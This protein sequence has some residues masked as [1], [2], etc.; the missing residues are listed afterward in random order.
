M[1]DEWSDAD[2]LRFHRSRMPTPREIPR[3][4]RRLVNQRRVLALLDESLRSVGNDR[5]PVVK[6]LLGQRG[7]GKSTVAV[8]WA[9]KYGEHF[10]DGQLFANLGAWTDHTVAPGEVLRGFLVSLGV[11]AGDVPA[12]LERRASMFRTLTSSRKY[13]IVLDDAVSPAQVRALLPNR[14]GSFVLVTGHGAFA[15]LKQVGAEL[16][17]VAPLEQDGAVELLREFAE[18]RVDAE[19]EALAGILDRCGGLPIALCQVGYVLAEDPGLSLADLLEEV[20]DQAGGMTQMSLGDMPSLASIFGASY[21]RLNDVEQRCYRALGLAPGGGPLPVAAL[22]ATLD[23]PPLQARRVVRELV[24]KKI[25]D[26]PETGSLVVHNLIREHARHLS[27]A[28]DSDDERGVMRMSILRWYETNA[29]AADNKLNPLRGW[30]PRIFPDVPIGPSPADPG[31]WLN[32]ER[33]NLRWAVSTAYELGLRDVVEHLC[34][35]LWSL[36]EPRKYYDD[37]LATHELGLQMTSGN[38]LARA[39]MLVQTSFALRYKGEYEEALTRCRAAAAI[40][41]NAKN[42]ELEATA[43]EAAG[44]TELDRDN[45]GEAVRL[46]RRN[47]ELAE[48]IGDSRRIALARMHLAKAEEPYGA[49]D[50]LGQAYEAFKRLGDDRN[51][52]KVL[53]WQGRR[54]RERG[55]LVEADRRLAQ[56]ADLLAEWP[57]DLAQ[58][59]DERG[60]IAASRGNAAARTYYE[61]ALELY[62]TGG[63]LTAA[64]ATRANLLSLPS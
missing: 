55:D 28:M 31:T 32:N 59:L 56:A 19:P 49:L 8:H 46:L 27:E 26:E 50:Q 11:A 13:L 40:A 54:L 47:L 15:S 30:W 53:T 35:A 58:V 39:L 25:I 63:H 62:E 38:D 23:L 18:D 51:V 12:E 29:I 10:P 20:S 52:G 9:D 60:A 4:V 16:I 36:Y 21:R 37:L 7:C 57:Y 33:G 6:V 3:P 42:L 44:L 45:Y 14:G 2:D 1:A 22:A 24:V 64:A 48:S 17:D 41:A 61:Q 5:E 34:V 43:V